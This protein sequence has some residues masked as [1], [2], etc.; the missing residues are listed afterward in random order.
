MISSRSTKKC[1]SLPVGRKVL[2]AVSIAGH[3]RMIPNAV[4]LIKRTNRKPLG[5]FR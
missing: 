4:D 3:S 2:C 1:Q 5:G